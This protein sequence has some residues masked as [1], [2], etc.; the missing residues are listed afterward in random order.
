MVSIINWDELWKLMRLS[1]PLE[2]SRRQLLGQEG[3]ALQRV[4]DEKKGAGTGMAIEPSKGTLECLKKDMERERVENIV[5]VNKRWEDVELGI[6]VEPHD[7]VIYDV[8][9][10][11]VCGGFGIPLR[12]GLANEVYIVTSA[13]YL[14]ILRP[15]TSAE[16]HGAS[17]REGRPTRWHNLQ[18]EG[19]C[20]RHLHRGGV[21]EE[22]RH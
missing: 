3:E 7:V 20:R 17:L 16:E 8:P 5:Y 19:R 12:R 4:L 10:D 18:R 21:R 2:D 15:T 14:S 1:S 11:I 22:S 6:D 13:D 9:G